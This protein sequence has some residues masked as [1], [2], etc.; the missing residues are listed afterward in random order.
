MADGT[1]NA[2]N[3]GE[4]STIVD[5]TDVRVYKYGK[6]VVVSI[7]NFNRGNGIYTITNAPVSRT[8]SAT[9]LTNGAINQGD[10]WIDTNT[11]TINVHQTS[12]GPCFGS[13]TYF[14]D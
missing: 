2:S 10:A 3:I 7:H 11:T 12:T 6:V 5:V 13:F 1:T 8:Y 4:I 14:T 9:I